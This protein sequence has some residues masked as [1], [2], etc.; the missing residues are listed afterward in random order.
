MQIPTDKYWTELGNPYGKV[1][2]MIE[3]SQRDGNPI[4]RPTV[5][6]YQEPWE[7]PETEPPTREHTW[8]GLRPMATYVAEGC[9]V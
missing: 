5:S 1:R 7:L 4:G 9:H 8:A 2:G 3:G 6:N